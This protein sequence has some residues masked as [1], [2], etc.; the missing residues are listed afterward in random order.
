MLHT[1]NFGRTVP[2]PV[3]PHSAPSSAHAPLTPA[4]YVALRRKAAGLSVE[5]VAERLSRRACDQ[6]EIR[7]LVRQLETPG[8]TAR[9]VSSLDILRDAFPL[10][11][12]VYFQ[13]AFEPVDRH[14]RVCRG[15]GCSHW[16]LCDRGEAGSCTWAS[17]EICTRCTDGELL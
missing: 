2:R 12:N 7:A 16:D 4:A 15:C 10:D 5:Q 11:P 6:A 8:I 1:P 3:A 13:L 9:H 17:E 14:P